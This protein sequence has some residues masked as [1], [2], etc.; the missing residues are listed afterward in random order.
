MP[1]YKAPLRDMRFLI[2][3]LLD[4][5]GHYA[6]LPNGGE[7]T[8]DVV[9][10]ILEE[11]AKYCEN[12]AAPLYQ[13]GDVEGCT[14]KDGVVTT[15]K[16]YK[17]AYD[18]F[19]EGGWV[20]LSHPVEYGGQG[21]PMSLGVFKSDMLGTANW[22]FNMYPGLSLGAM[23]TLMLHG[24]KEQKDL[25]MPP[26][27]Q[28][29]WMG[30]M[31]LTEPQCGTDLGQVSTKA[32]PR[33]DGT[34]EITGTKIFIS[35]G[36]QDLTENIVHIALARIPGSPEGTRGISLFIIPKFV[37]NADGS[38][39]EFN[40]VVCSALEHKMGIKASATCT[41][42]FEGSTGYL[43]GPVNK[44]LESMFTFMNTAR[45][46]T[47]LQAVCATELSYQGAVE[48]AKERRSMR[49]LSGKKEPDKVADAIIHHGDV[50]RMLLTMKAVVE[51]GRAMIYHTAKMADHMTIAA[52]KGDDKERILWDER[53]G[54][55]TPILKGFLT[56]LAVE[57]TNHGMQVF[58]GHGYIREHGMEQIARDTRISTMYEGTTSIQ[59]LD[60]LGRKV[61]IATKGKVIAEYTAEIMKFCAE[62]ATNPKMMPFV[63][64]LGKI[65][66]Q[67][68][69]LTLRTAAFASKNRD[70]VGAAA[71]DFLMYS[72]Y[73]MMAFFWAKMA[74]KAFEKLASGDGIETKEFYQSKIQTAEFYF[75]RLL[76]RTKAHA[77]AVLAP[78]S[79]TMQMPI[80]SFIFR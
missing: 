5:P 23:N 77:S 12:V 21:M 78:A 7:A 28:G 53:I 47:A 80:D 69:F 54:F 35:S 9:E 4:Y 34:Y 38:V 16:G 31:C 25:Y 51:G 14:L 70:V 10:S 52:E 2:N 55:Y 11:C 49:S 58:G 74:A 45:I 46:G 32:V 37:P 1:Q 24:T 73:A 61:L 63:I 30:T 66:A 75:D 22:P 20:G 56:E 26:L 27:V 44:G 64:T 3:E 59:S 65:C 41:I 8:P 18:L 62:H 13:S 71:Y 29:Q 19:V 60:L 36:D 43:L 72:G 67:W 57:C 68:N 79:A 17:R 50:R 15:P 39:G 40:K 6:K 42:E 76:P 33:G 48:Y